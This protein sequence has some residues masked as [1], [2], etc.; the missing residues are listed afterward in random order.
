MKTP[1]LAAGVVALTLGGADAASAYFSANTID[2]HATHTSGGARVRA[3]GPIGCT[4]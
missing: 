2:G 3:T 4:S 1:L